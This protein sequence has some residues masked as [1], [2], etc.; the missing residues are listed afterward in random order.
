VFPPEQGGAR[1]SPED[2]PYLNDWCCIAAGSFVDMVIDSIFGADLTLHDGIRVRS[3]LEHFDP[4][5]RLLDLPYQG[6]NYSISL[7][8]VDKA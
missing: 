2:A 3:R 4:R 1:K 6:K 5:A 8:G 7:D